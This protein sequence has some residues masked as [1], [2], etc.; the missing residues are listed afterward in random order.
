M[1]PWDDTF[2]PSLNTKGKLRARMGRSPI[3]SRYFRWTSVR[4]IK[5]FLLYLIILFFIYMVLMPNSIDGFYQ[6]SMISNAYLPDLGAENSLSQSPTSIIAYV[7]I[8]NILWNI[9]N[10]DPLTTVRLFG[11]L[12][13]VSIFILYSIIFEMVPGNRFVKE[14][15]KYGYPLVLIGLNTSILMGYVISFTVT[16]GFII[17]I[18][19][20]RILNG[21]VSNYRIRFFTIMVCW[22]AIGLY[23]HSYHVAIL[24]LVG[25]MAFTGYVY[26]IMNNRITSNRKMINTVLV[27]TLLLIVVFIMIWSYMRV[28]M[29]SG[30]LNN[31]LN[32][33]NIDILS[34]LFKKGSTAGTFS[35][36]SQYPT[37]AIDTLRYVSYGI[38]YSFLFITIIMILWHLITKRPFGSKYVI[39]MALLL[40][41]FAYQGLY[42]I[43]TRSAAPLI[44]LIFT[45]PF[46]LILFTDYPLPKFRGQG[47]LKR[48]ITILVV[49]PLIL[50]S[51]MNI[52]SYVTESPEKNV[53]LD[54]LQYGDQWL[55]NNI[56]GDVTVISDA[57]TIGHYAIFQNMNGR[58]FDGISVDSIGTGR[59][60]ELTTGIF[61]KEMDVDS[62]VAINHVM[63]ED[64]LIFKS[65]QA[66]NKFE[67]L[68]PIYLRSNPHINS[69]YFDGFVT[70]GQ[71]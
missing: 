41:D 12:S 20:Y 58:E 5:I 17:F 45:I 9:C 33:L 14:S 66:W 68:D 21:D 36:V 42:F 16:L 67:P 61:I 23:W 29:L 56:E 65:L 51:C 43:T 70:I 24:L 28:D 52:A 47:F 31:V 26:M 54:I 59:Y 15:L 63:Y 40:A 64:H 27:S 50:T 37:G 48:A 30:I 18:Y 6:A 10:I 62:Y 46:F 44:L 53:H 11:F 1:I 7:I 2:S 49:V 60:S 69:I 38:V 19:F 32:N 34:N 8:I 22:I 71:S 3:S 57:H 25:A 55:F 39:L 4:D 35:F 13:I